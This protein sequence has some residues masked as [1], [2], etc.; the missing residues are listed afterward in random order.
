MVSEA[1]HAQRIAEI[2]R[3]IAQ[4]RGR[5]RLVLMA[6]PSSSGKTTFSRRLTVQLLANGLRP[7]PIALD[8]YFLNRDDTPKDADGHSG[9]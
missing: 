7:F 9:L 1:F 4:D 2:A 8:D 6:G 5:I 3:E